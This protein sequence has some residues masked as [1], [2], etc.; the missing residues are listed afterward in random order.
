LLYEL[1]RANDALAS[2]NAALS[3]I[4]IPPTVRRA[5]SWGL[6]VKQIGIGILIAFSWKA[7][8]SV[9]GYAIVHYKIPGMVSTF[10][11]VHSPTL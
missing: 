5:A 1:K 7:T 2:A 3:Q 6:G 11:V 9:T 4:Q 10:I 8:V